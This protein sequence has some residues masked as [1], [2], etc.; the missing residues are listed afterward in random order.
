MLRKYCTALVC[1]NVLSLQVCTPGS[2][3]WMWTPRLSPLTAHS[4]TSSSL[5]RRQ[6]CPTFTSSGKC[7]TSSNY[8][9]YSSWLRI[10]E[11]VIIC[12]GLS[13]LCF[14]RTKNFL[15]WAT[16]HHAIFL[17]PPRR[18]IYL[19]TTSQVTTTVYGTGIFQQVPNLRHLIR[20]HQ[21]L[22]P[23][24]YVTLLTY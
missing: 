5:E 18:P 17:G 2:P 16:C 24:R 15:F 21:F 14:Y 23:F 6:V 13:L 12:K 20:V 22:H 8:R 11:D 10:K 9:I 4:L 7:I 1:L 3:R 19:A